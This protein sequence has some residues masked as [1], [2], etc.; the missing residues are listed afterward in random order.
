MFSPPFLSSLFSLFLHLLHLLLSS[1]SSAPTR[2]STP[3]FHH[4]SAV[5]H[6][7]YGGRRRTEGA[8]EDIRTW[9]ITLKAARQNF[10]PKNVNVLLFFFT[11]LR[12][13]LL[14]VS[15][16][17][18]RVRLPD[19]RTLALSPF[20]GC[21]RPAQRALCAGRAPVRARRQA[22]AGRREAAGY[23]GV[24]HCLLRPTDGAALVAGLGAPLPCPPPRLR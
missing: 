16:P 15:L 23:V 17:P 18:L 14:V 7:G 10:P 2:A 4:A 20:A 1:S 21:A 19:R 12:L 22:T 11:L 9:G 8:T 6:C 24:R 3:A 13:F 5:W